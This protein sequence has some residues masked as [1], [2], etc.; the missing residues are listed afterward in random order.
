MLICEQLLML[1]RSLP[2]PS[3]GHKMSTTTRTWLARVMW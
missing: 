3:S 2:H 1:Q